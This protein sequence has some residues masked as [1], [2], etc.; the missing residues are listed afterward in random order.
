MTLSINHN[1]NAIIAIPQYLLLIIIVLLILLPILFY[2]A[3]RIERQTQINQL[4]KDLQTMMI[5]AKLLSQYADHASRLTKDITIPQSVQYVSFQSP[6]M[7][8]VNNS[9]DYEWYSTYQICY[10]DGYIEKF[11][12]PDNIVESIPYR[13][14][15]GTHQ[16]IVELINIKD[17]TYVTMQTIE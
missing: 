6:D 10:D 16:I 11:Q 7:S 4:K 9:D 2:G 14:Y 5:S 1:R 3:A 13:L 17:K 12:A 8:Q 15:Q